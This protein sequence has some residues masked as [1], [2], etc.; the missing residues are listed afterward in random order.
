[1]TLPLRPFRDPPTTDLSLA[2]LRNLGPKSAAMLADIGITDKNRLA[3][4]GAVAVC[5]Q[6]HEAGHAVS[7]NLAYA[8]EGALMDVDWRE[9]PPEFRRQLQKEWQLVQRRRLT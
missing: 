4:A 2:H 6:L 3:E 8:I 7:L 9:L 5:Q 1:M